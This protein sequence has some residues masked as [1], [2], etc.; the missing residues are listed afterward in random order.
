M[1]RLSG[2][3]GALLLMAAILLALLV[4]DAQAGGGVH[5]GAFSTEIV[6]LPFL[7][8]IRRIL[9]KPILFFIQTGDN[10]E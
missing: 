3:L 8:Q 4:G 9:M 10:P 6:A 5:A 7:L 1:R 2:D